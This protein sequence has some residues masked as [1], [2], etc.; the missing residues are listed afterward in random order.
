MTLPH[1]CCV[2]LTLKVDIF[3]DFDI[4]I[5]P[6]HLGVHW[7]LAVSYNP[8]YVQ[9]IRTPVQCNIQYIGTYSTH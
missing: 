3:K 7:T 1:P 2:T 8:T 6:V 9:Y 5:V 4:V